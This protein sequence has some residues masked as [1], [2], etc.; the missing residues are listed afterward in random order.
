MHARP[1]AEQDEHSDDHPEPVA[2]GD[3]ES[4]AFDSQFRSAEMPEDED[5]FCE[6]PDGDLERDDEEGCGRIS[7]PAKDG[8]EQLHARH[9]ERERVDESQVRNAVDVETRI[10]AGERKEESGNAQPDGGNRGRKHGAQKDHLA[11]QVFSAV[12]AALADCPGDE[13][14]APEAQA[15]DHH[16]HDLTQDLVH[17]DD[18][19]HRRVAQLRDEGKVGHLEDQKQAARGD[20][21]E[22]QGEERGEQAA[23]RVVATAQAAKRGDGSARGRGIRGHLVGPAALELRFREVSIERSRRA[24]GDVSGLAGAGIGGVRHPV[25]IA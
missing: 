12:D 14:L 19:G 2:R 21:R 23:P 8:G 24:P 9:A 22:R 7:G 16:H 6:D 10:G 13:S 11:R 3:A 25:L 4:D 1:P 15:H 20:H 18:G 5:P 17:D